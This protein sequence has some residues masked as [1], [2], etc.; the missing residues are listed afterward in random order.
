MRLAITALLI[1]LQLLF[2]STPVLAAYGPTT[3]T[4]S[5]EEGFWDKYHIVNPASAGGDVEKIYKIKKVEFRLVA[6]EREFGSHT[7]TQE[8]GSPRKFNLLHGVAGA[9]TVRIKA[10]AAEENVI[11]V[12][13]HPY[14]YAGNDILIKAVPS[15]I[16][17][18]YP[19]I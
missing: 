16:T 18:N 19:G 3:I 15:G 14:K 8:A 12:S 10:S 17:V 1:S 11:W 7:F 5:V 13:S 9:L 6:G 4:V 2:T